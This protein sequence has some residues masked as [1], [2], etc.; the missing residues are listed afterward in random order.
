MAD[1]AT[2]GNN[3][4]TTL[5]QIIN[6]LDDFKGLTNDQKLNTPFTKINQQE[7]LYEDIESLQKELNTA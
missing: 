3:E 4:N 2:H 7:C 5:E 1:L 6:H